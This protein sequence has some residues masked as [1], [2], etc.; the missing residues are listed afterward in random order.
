MEKLTALRGGIVKSDCSHNAG[1]EAPI[2]YLENQL[3]SPEVRL[4][5]S[6][7][8]QKTEESLWGLIR[9]I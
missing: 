6:K 1:I 8:K 9:P 7:G 5:T 4:N 3:G 2:L